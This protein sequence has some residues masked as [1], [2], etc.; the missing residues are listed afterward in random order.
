MSSDNSIEVEFGA[1]ASGVKEGADQAKDAVEG[2]AQ[3]AQSSIETLKDIAAA[4]TSAFA[5]DK[6]EEFARSMASAGQQMERMSS[7]TGLSVGQVEDFQNQIRVMGGDAENAGISLMRLERNLADAAANAEGPAADAFHRLGVSQQMLEGGNL[8]EILG[9]MANKMADTADGANKLNAM[10]I[11][12]G[13]GGMQLIAMLDQGKI[14]LDEITAAVDSTG[15][16]IAGLA[17]KFN[18]SAQGFTLFDI[19]QEKAGAYI[20]S[21]LE[22]GFDAI[23]LSLTRMTA[24]FTENVKEGGKWSDFLKEVSQL[25]TSVA[26]GIRGVSG[27]LEVMADK[28]VA[29]F[30]ALAD[31][32]KGDFAQAIRD[33]AAGMEQAAQAQERWAADA[34]QI[35]GA[36]AGAGIGT[37]VGGPSSGK[38]R[39][40]LPAPTSDSGD[41]DLSSQRQAY[42]EAY[43]VKKEY[44]DLMVQS[45]QMSHQQELA[46]LLQ[47]LDQENSLVEQ[48]LMQQQ[49]QYQIG[50]DD[51]LKLQNEMNVQAE[52]YAVERMKITQ[53]EVQQDEK[54]WT[55]GLDTIDKSMDTMLT[56][57][58]QGT[59]TIGEAFQRMTSNMVMSFIEAI[60]KMVLQWTASGLY[61]LF[62][63]S[64]QNPFGGGNQSNQGGQNL[65]QQMVSQ[66]VEWISTT[67]LQTSSETANTAAIV[68]NTAALSTSSVLSTGSG[69]GSGGGFLGGIIGG[70]IPYATGTPYVPKDMPAFIHEGEMIIPRG[71]SDAIRAGEASVGG[72]GVSVHFHSHSLD[73]S[74]AAAGFARNSSAIAKAV[75]SASRGGNSAIRRAFAGM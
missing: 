11:V 17:E 35:A 27:Y 70:L 52:K 12:A 45:G 25:M 4:V 58:L 29:A 53:Q 21:T 71:Q 37:G 43:D 55:Q 13:R 3:S 67:V 16:S 54:A 15:P 51:Y 46:D 32:L 20:Y 64:N 69:S 68:A 30:K 28:G 57:V 22:P 41:K 75:L 14:G 65:A 59:Q 39:V 18:Q 1:D 50:S 72:G 23:V 47:A 6:I 19:A 34:A 73:P 24:N 26:L 10:M 9:A 60:A 2:F 42:S 44:D 33:W 5:I 49:A 63:G 36:G 8:T 48:S 56:G 61:Q 7:M 66:M 62:S 40:G 74:A 31:A 38:G